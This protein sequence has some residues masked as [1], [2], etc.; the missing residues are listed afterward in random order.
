M[1][2]Y[3]S[4]VELFERFQPKFRR[5]ELRPSGAKTHSPTNPGLSEL[6]LY[7]SPYHFGKDERLESTSI[8]TDLFFDF[9]KMPFTLNFDPEGDSIQEQMVAV[10]WITALLGP[11]KDVEI[12]V[13]PLWPGMTYA[14][15]N[16]EPPDSILDYNSFELNLN[17]RPAPG[18][19]LP[20]RTQLIVP[21]A[22]RAFIPQ[23]PER[24]AIETAITLENTRKHVSSEVADTLNR[25]EA[26]LDQ[27]LQ[28]AKA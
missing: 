7:L 2:K 6:K 14:A 26:A 28:A 15:L 5:I 21:S 8:Q 20:L 3:P 24:E 25:L 17:N 12:F 19:H 10:V 11:L 18:L 9:R 1:S 13:K 22:W 23:G 4:S 27:H 16:P